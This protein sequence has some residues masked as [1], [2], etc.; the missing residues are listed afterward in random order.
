MAVIDCFTFNGEFDLL[1]IRL[2]VLD[3]FVDEFIIV[4]APTTFSGKP[5]PLY[6]EETKD[7]YKKW[8]DKI[9][10]FVIDE[11]Y[12]Q[13]EHEQARNSPNTQGASHWKHEFMQKE[14]IKKALTHLDDEDIVFIGDVDEIWDPYRCFWPKTILKLGLKV[15]TYYLNNRS[16]EQFHGTICGFYKY[17]KNECL[18]HIRTFTY[19]TPKEYGWHFT[20]MGGVEEVRRKLTDSYTA[21][22]YAHGTVLNN[23]ESAI[24]NRTDFLGRGFEYWKDEEGWPQWLKDNKDK[25]KHLML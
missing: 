13:Q 1:E 16:N 3:E 17:I 21:E 20:S 2:N 14:S 25:Y 12:T 7:R 18:N 19:R 23:L 4:E 22:S 6:Y 15:Y 9:K 11:Q 5:K 8:H 10:Y 24:I